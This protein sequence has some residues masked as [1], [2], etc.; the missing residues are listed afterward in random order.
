M[1]VR[2]ELIK[3]VKQAL[4][5]IAIADKKVFEIIDLQK[6]QFD[7]P[8]KSYGTIYT[9]SLVEI[10]EI[11]W[12]AMTNRK[13]EGQATVRV[14][15]YTKEGFADQFYTTPDPEEGLDEIDIQDSVE[16]KLDSFKGE[17]FKPLALTSEGTLP[18]SHFGQMVYKL[19]FSTWV[20]KQLKSKYVS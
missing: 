18:A 14:Y 13:K 4:A 15:I 17:C 8:E 5:E 3:A 10:D 11:R 12:E 1:S 9:A 19:E 7:N 20:Y 16:E 6:G 2:K